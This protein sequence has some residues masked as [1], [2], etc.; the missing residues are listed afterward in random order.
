MEQ[1]AVAYL[2]RAVRG[3]CARDDLHPPI[4]INTEAN[5]ELAPCSCL[6]SFGRGELLGRPPIWKQK[7]GL[8]LRL[9]KAFT[10][11]DS[12]PLAVLNQLVKQNQGVPERSS[13]V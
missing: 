12:L 3:F 5:I 1:T 11:H 6:L 9:E 2:E 7:E 13:K 4:E 8:Q 10:R